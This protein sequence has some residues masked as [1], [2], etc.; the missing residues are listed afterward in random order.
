MASAG[1]WFYTEKRALDTNVK[2][3]A[4]NYTVKLGSADNLFM[5][6]RVIAVVDPADNITITVGNAETIGQ[7]LFLVTTSNSG[8]K[9]VTVSVT[10]HMTSDPETFTMTTANQWLEL[11]WQGNK[12]GTVA[13]NATAT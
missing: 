11:V 12:W 9:T 13:G 8:S 5:I 3:V 2:E 4:D 6:D 7:R 1:N 10:K